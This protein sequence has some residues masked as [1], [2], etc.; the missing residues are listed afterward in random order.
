MSNVYLAISRTDQTPHFSLSALGQSA[1]RFLPFVPEETLQHIDPHHRWALFGWSVLPEGA[2]GSYWHQ[3]ND[4]WLT[5]NGW[6]SEGEGEGLG[7][8]DLSDSVAAVASQRLSRQGFHTYCDNTEG[9]WSLLHITADGQIRAACDFLGGQHLYYGEHRGVCAVSNRAMLVAAALNQGELPSLQP[10]FFSMLFMAT[11]APIGSHTPFKHVSLLLQNQRLQIVNGRLT[12]SSNH[13]PEPDGHSRTELPDWDTHHRGLLQ[14]VTQ[15]Q[16]LPDLSWSVALTGGKDSRLVFAAL[17]DSGAIDAVD[18]A[19]LHAHPDHPDVALGEQLASHYGLEF[20]RFD[21]SF[22]DDGFLDALEIHNVQTEYALNAWDLRTRT[23]RPRQGTLHG[24]YGEIYRGHVEPQFALGWGWVHRKY[25]RPG[26]LDIASLMT[27]TA[28]S[29]CR[30]Q[31]EHWIEARQAEQSPR[32]HLHDRFHRE[33]RMQRWM[34]QVQLSNALATVMIAPIPSRSLL[35]LYRQ[36]SLRDRQ[37]ERVH[38]ELMRRCDPWLARQPF[39]N[40]SWSPW[41][42]QTRRFR[43]PAFTRSAHSRSRQIAYWQRYQDEI[44]AFLLNEAPSAL[45]EI[46]DPLALK[47]LLDRAGDTPDFVSLRAIFAAAGVRHALDTPYRPRHLTL[48]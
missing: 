20:R 18:Y 45:F 5:Y 36:L 15:I 35:H 19:F 8:P 32:L 16:N 47:D 10:E 9:E 21:P 1:A 43:T 40:D 48:S 2:R 25:L 38:F 31:L 30:R 23:E 39:A 14:R 7:R 28:R 24:C 37:T 12:R 29:Y 41:L 6:I 42:P 4:H 11:A 13:A 26:Y 46:L 17:I 27:P 34:G 3:A 33:M 44:R 22:P